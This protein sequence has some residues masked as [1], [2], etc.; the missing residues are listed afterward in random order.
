MGNSLSSELQLN[1]DPIVIPDFDVEDVLDSFQKTYVIVFKRLD[2]RVAWELL[3]IDLKIFETL[4]ENTED[5]KRKSLYF[6]IHNILK[7]FSRAGDGNSGEMLCEKGYK[8]GKFLTLKEVD[9]NSNADEFRKWRE[10]SPF[11]YFLDPAPVKSELLELSKIRPVTDVFDRK[12]LSCAFIGFDVAFPDISREYADL[13]N[14]SS[15]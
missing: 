6:G 10:Q 14:S 4:V 9:E 1:T 3:G 13:V 7:T 2:S 8:Y 15:S 5:P 12:D 11:R